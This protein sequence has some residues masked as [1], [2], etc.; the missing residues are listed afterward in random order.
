MSTS[1]PWPLGIGILRDLPPVTACLG[2][3]VPAY[4]AVMEERPRRA[5]P[6]PAEEAVAGGRWWQEAA[7]FRGTGG[8]WGSVLRLQ[9]RKCISSLQ[10][11]SSTL[12]LILKYSMPSGLKS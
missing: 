5:P 1:S 4:P 7:G 8:G 9:R 2:F 10:K 12:N 3:L 11:S 6:G